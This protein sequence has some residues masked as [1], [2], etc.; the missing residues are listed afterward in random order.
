M[1][2]TSDEFDALKQEHIELK[3]MVESLTD[4]LNALKFKMEEE[5]DS[6]ESSEDSEVREEKMRV[7][8]KNYNQL[9]KIR[10]SLRQGILE[11]KMY[12]FLKTECNTKRTQN[13]VINAYREYCAVHEK[14][15]GA[16]LTFAGML[17]EMKA[18]LKL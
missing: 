2:A 17:E 18:V 15:C 3:K 6:S 8:K 5:S 9:N 4:E 14:E 1:A 10:K 12:E 16:G 13:N 7:K 11:K